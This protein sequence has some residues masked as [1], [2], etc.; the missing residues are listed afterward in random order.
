MRLSTAL[1]ARLL[2]DDDLPLDAVLRTAGSA[3][4]DVDDARVLENVNTLDDY[5]ALLLRSP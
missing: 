1:R 2:G 4:V 3:T 5:R